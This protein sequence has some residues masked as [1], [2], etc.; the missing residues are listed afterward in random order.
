MSTLRRRLLRLEGA[1]GRRGF[2]D[3]PDSELDARLRAE[4]AAWL[5][6]D[7]D[8]YPVDAR[9]EVAAF[10]AVADAGECRSWRRA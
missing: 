6:R 3:L 4:L 1:R 10:L 5:R 7:P 9:V 2:S 8:A